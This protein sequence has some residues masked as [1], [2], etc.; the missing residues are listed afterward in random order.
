MKFG[1]NSEAQGPIERNLG[2][3]VGASIPRRRLD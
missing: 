1:R 3:V 2:N